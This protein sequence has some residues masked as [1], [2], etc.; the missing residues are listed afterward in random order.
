MAKKRFKA[1]QIVAILREAERAGS[2]EAVIRKYIQG[3]ETEDRRL[4]QLELPTKPVTGETSQET[5]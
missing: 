3:Q 1:E 5:N 2:N 4:D